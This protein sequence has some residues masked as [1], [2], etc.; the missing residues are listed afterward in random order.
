MILWRK[1]SFAIN[2][3]STARRIS[4]E[5]ISKNVENVS[6]IAK[7]TA[8]G[9]QQSAAAAE[10]LNRQAETMRQMVAKFRIHENAG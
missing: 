1:S 6:S 9:A 5:E 4:A 10:Q 2:S 3:N 7:E 8:A